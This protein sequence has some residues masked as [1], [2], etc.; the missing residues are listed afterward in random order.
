MEYELI[1][2]AEGT[3]LKLFLVSINRRVTHYHSDIELFMVLR[4]SVW[5]STGN[6]R[7]PLQ[8][9]DI[10]LANKYE[11]H[12]LSRADDENVLL[13]VQFDPNSFKQYFPKISNI[14]FTQRLINEK[15]NKAYWGSLNECFG[16]LFR[17]YRK[18]CD[19]YQLEMMGILNHLLFSMVQHDAYV[20]LKE[21][22]ISAEKRNMKRITRILDYLHQNYMHQVTL[23][24]LAKEEGLDMYYLSSLIKKQLGVSFQEYLTHLR[25]EKA[26]Q[27]LA[28]TDLNHMDIC[29]E[30]GFSDYKYLNN[31]F[32]KRMGCLPDEYRQKNRKAARVEEEQTE[33]HRIMD[34]ALADEMLR[35][36]F[37][38]V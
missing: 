30:C 22:E 19:G 28:H 18:K 8:R 7:Y 9:D 26:Q 34:A 23:K 16:G 27:L 21:K 2:H 6:E 5:V 33:Q 31:S 32:I 4:G 36:R 35:E 3:N 29:M 38:A 25:V 10:F 12:S 37:G 11:M 14:K 24:A 1:R 15:T 13:V 17:S 20:E